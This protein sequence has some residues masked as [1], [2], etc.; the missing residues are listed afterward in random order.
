MKQASKQQHQQ[1]LNEH[2]QHTTTPHGNAKH[3]LTSAA[4]GGAPPL[5]AGAAVT[6]AAAEH[7]SRGAPV[8]ERMHLR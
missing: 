5:A 1:W 4:A 2:T 8:N 7:T 6:A 3:T